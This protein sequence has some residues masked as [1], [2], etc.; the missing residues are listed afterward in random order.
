MSEFK[1]TSII[2]ETCYFI[3]IKLVPIPDV[4]YSISRLSED[5]TVVCLYVSLLLCADSDSIQ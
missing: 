4:P 3:L 5:N 2:K 1:L